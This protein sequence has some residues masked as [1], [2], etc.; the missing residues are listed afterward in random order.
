M[1]KSTYKRRLT[2]QERKEQEQKSKTDTQMITSLKAKLALLKQQKNP[3]DKKL[4]A[5]INEDDAELS[6]DPVPGG[7]E[8]MDG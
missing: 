7:D 4:S 2:K 3:E 5:M 8:Q 6:E 1:M